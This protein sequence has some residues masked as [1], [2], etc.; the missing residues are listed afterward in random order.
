MSFWNILEQTPGNGWRKQDLQLFKLS[1]D[2]LRS[3]D[4]ETNHLF[5]PTVSGTVY[6]QT[7][8]PGA[9]MEEQP[10][11]EWTPDPLVGY[12]DGDD[13]KEAPADEIH[14]ALSS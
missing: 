6:S 9:P 1:H 12:G 3:D 11:D 10:L 8:I 13:T 5:F 2:I 14:Q 4:S 7:R